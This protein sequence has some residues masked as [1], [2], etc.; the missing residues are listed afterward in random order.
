MCGDDKKI[1][2]PEGAK[3]DSSCI[4]TDNNPA[5]ASQACIATCNA[6][7]SANGYTEIQCDVNSWGYYGTL[8][9]LVC[10]PLTCTSSPDDTGLPENAAYHCSDNAAYGSVCSATCNAGYYAVGARTATCTQN[11]GMYSA[12]APDA[13]A[14]KLLFSGAKWGA[15]NGNLKCLPGKR[16]LSIHPHKVR[17]NLS[18]FTRNE[19]VLW[20][21]LS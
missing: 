2:L 20:T 1:F 7:Y 12:R 21:A 18:R 16:P 9:T 15:F 3:W 17:S 10:T 6:G 5:P 11:I 8:N 19:V 14:R 13:H 4:W